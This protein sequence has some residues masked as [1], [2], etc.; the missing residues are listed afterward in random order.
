[1]LAAISVEGRVVGAERGRRVIDGKLD[2]R[3]Q[4]LPVVAPVASEGAQDVGYDAVDVLD[5]AGCVVTISTAATD[6]GRAGQG[7][8]LRL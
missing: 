1:M 3:H 2:E 6:Q 5:L 7:R 8:R 4:V